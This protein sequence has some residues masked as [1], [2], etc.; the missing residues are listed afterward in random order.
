LGY[1]VLPFLQAINSC[2]F[3]TFGVLSPAVRALHIIVIV[4]FDRVPVSHSSD[5]L[6]GGAILFELLHFLGESNGLNELL[7]LLTPFLRFPATTGG[8]RRGS[9]TSG[10]AWW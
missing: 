1:D 2:K 10:V 9:W 4:G 6:I 5:L 7:V 8:T 3:L